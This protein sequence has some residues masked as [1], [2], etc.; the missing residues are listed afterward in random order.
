[1]VWIF[2]SFFFLPF[3]TFKNTLVEVSYP[4]FTITKNL[5]PHPQQCK[6][7]EPNKLQ[8][9]LLTG[10]AHSQLTD[11]GIQQLLLVFPN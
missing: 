5:K 11:P 4:N 6:Q 1:M 2:F 7:S 10:H 8:L 9:L 3:F